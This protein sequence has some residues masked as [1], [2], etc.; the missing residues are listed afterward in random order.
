[1]KIARK[2]CKLSVTGE[3]FSEPTLMLEEEVNKV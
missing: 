2:L 1:M 3:F